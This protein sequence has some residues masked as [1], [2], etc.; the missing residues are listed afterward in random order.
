MYLLT[1]HVPLTAMNPMT[2]PAQATTI[3]S[4]VPQSHS[5]CPIGDEDWVTFTLENDSEVIFE[6][7]GH[8]GDTQMWL[9]DSSL[10]EIEFN[11]DGGTGSSSRIDRL[12]GTDELPAGTYYVKIEESGSGYEINSYD[13]SWISK[14]SLSLFASLR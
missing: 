11:D 8:G 3:I 6:I 10:I 2:V 4:G 14:I 5:I 12:C 1:Q 9:Y 13:I 7:S